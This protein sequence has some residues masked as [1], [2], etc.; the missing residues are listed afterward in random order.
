MILFPYLKHYQRLPSSLSVLGA[1]NSKL[2]PFSGQREPIRKLQALP[3]IPDVFF[4]CAGC[5]QNNSIKEYQ[6]IYEFIKDCTSLSKIANGE[7]NHRVTTWAMTEPKSLKPPLNSNSNFLF[8][9]L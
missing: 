3:Q 6:R 9:T 2:L 1:K 7:K 5:C 4:G 8:K